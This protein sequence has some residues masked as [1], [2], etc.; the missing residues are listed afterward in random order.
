MKLN[1]F[2]YPL[3]LEQ[4]SYRAEIFRITNQYLSMLK[5][6]KKTSFSEESVLLVENL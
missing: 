6:I 3:F 2:D 4:T 5:K 1:H